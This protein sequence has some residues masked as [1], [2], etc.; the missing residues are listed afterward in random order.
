MSKEEIK[1][2]KYLLIY[3]NLTIGSDIDLE[4]IAK[5]E[6][7]KLLFSMDKK[8]TM[9]LMRKHDVGVVMASCK[10][11]QDDSI[12]FLRYIMKQHPHTQRFYISDRIDRQL[13]ELVINKAHINYFLAL[14]VEKENLLQMIHKAFKRY[15]DVSKPYRRFDELA[16]ITVELIE[17]IEKYHEEAQTDQLTELMN[18]RA[19]DAFM[20]HSYN[21]YKTKG[22]SFS[23]VILDLDHFKILNDT[24]GHQAGDSVL[25]GFAEILKSQLRKADDVAF[26]YGGEEFAVIAR[27]AKTIHIKRSMDRILERIRDTEIQFEDKTMKFTFSAGIEEIG[28][29]MDKKELIKKADA[30]L[31]FAKRNGRNQNVIF[32]ESMLNQ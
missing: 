1:K 11:S 6:D 18:R 26:R 23:L 28:A 14:P 29:D 5:I 32:E 4:N 16:D 2:D 12:T 10:S 31:Y 17:D 27:G 25:K 9:D 22:I 3:G 20:E 15:N 24:Y 13:L 21:L 8:I 30:A 7:V 19:F